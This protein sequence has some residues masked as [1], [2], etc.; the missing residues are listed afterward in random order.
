MIAL[1]FYAMKYDLIA[2]VS[3]KPRHQCEVYTWDL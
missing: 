3:G 1:M 2:E